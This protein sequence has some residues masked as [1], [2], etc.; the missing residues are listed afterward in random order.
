MPFAHVRGVDLHYETQGSGPECLVIAHGALGSIAY[1]ERWG[2]PAEAL[3]AHGFRV[4]SY[5]AR[6][7]G[8]SGFTLRRADYLPAALAEDL[9]GLMDALGIDQANVYGTS[10]GAST[11]LM[12][13]SAHPQRVAKLVLRI[14]APFGSAMAKAR[15]R[16]Y[17]AAS[18]YRWFGQSIATTLVTALT[19]PA[20]RTKMS[21]LLS[22]QQRRA[23]EPAIRGFLHE[24]LNP[25]ILDTITAPALI[26][27]Q[28]DDAM[29]PLRS[30]EIL[31]DRLRTSTLLVAP[32][33]TRWEHDIAKLALTI[34]SWLK[35]SV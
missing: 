23:I 15:A 26:L 10:M 30:G 24:P 6:G 11:A 35:T 18:I 16:L 19:R 31:R 4:I 29:H 14:P 8:R 32:P 27:T 28:P 5:D 9:L 1:S 7:H 3:A 13:A 21:E 33:G 25:A 12:L 20:D 17:P 22:G 2:V 34:T